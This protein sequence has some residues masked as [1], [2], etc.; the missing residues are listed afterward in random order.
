MPRKPFNL[1]ITI[2]ATIRATIPAEPIARNLPTSLL[3][4]G[5]SYVNDSAS[6]CLLLHTKLTYFFSLLTSSVN[7]YIYLFTYIY[8]SVYIYDYEPLWS[9]THS[10][11]L[12]RIYC[13]RATGYARIVSA[14]SAFY[15]MQSN[16]HLAAI[17]Y[18]LSVLGDEFD[19]FAAR[20]LNQSWQLPHA[21]KNMQ[22]IHSI[23][24]RLLRCIRRVTPFTGRSI[25]TY[26]NTFYTRIPLCLQVAIWR[27]KP[28][29]VYNL[30]HGATV[31]DIPISLSL[32]N[33]EQHTTTGWPQ[34]FDSYIFDGLGLYINMW[35][36]SFGC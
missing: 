3:C 27:H 34:P 14:I 30:F 22:Y 24:P 16:P 10:S 8:L 19:G 13:V 33:S 9:G 28:V 25:A 18:G 11:V 6:R 32:Y 23:F 29:A 36:W 21:C 4:S 1:Y 20:R 26:C 17:L 12:L 31:L 35:F 2:C 15:F 5:I 7:Q